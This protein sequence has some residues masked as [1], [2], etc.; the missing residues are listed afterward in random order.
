M[1]FSDLRKRHTETPTLTVGTSRRTVGSFF[2]KAHE[3]GLAGLFVS[4]HQGKC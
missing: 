1:K 4:H 2:E 3:V